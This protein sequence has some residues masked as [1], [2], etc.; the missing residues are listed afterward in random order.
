[1]ATRKSRFSEDEEIIESPKTTRATRTNNAPVAEEE[2]NE[3]SSFFEDASFELAHS[4]QEQEFKK[5]TEREKEAI[6]SIRVSM[7]RFGK[8]LLFSMHN[9][10]NRTINLSPMCDLPIG[11]K[12]RPSSVIITELYDEEEDRTIYKATAEIM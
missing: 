5:L 1:M 10:K 9:G 4:W 6:K 3:E 12:V 11:A 2:T 8:Q 7:G